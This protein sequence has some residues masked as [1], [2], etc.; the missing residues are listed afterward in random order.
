M[1]NCLCSQFIISI[2]ISL[3]HGSHLPIM[4]NHDNLQSQLPKSSL[5]FQTKHVQTDA[6]TVPYLLCFINSSV[7]KILVSTSLINILWYSWL[8]IDNIPQEFI[9][10]V[11]NVLPIPPKLVTLC[12]YL[13]ITGHSRWH[14]QRSWLF[15]M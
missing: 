15:N 3:L 11:K 13:P 14:L 10:L 7:V 4:V 6:H 1:A 12:C 9:S 5:S 2:L 8:C